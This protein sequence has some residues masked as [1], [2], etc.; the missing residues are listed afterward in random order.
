MNLPNDPVAQLINSPQSSAFPLRRW[1]LPLSAKS[2][3]LRDQELDLVREIVLASCILVI[4]DNDVNIKLVTQILNSA[5]FKNVHSVIRASLALARIQDLKPDLIVLDLRMPFV[6][7][8]EIMEMM[9]A[10]ENYLNFGP[11]LVLTAD[12][13]VETKRKALDAGADDFLCYPIDAR[14]L[15]L[16]VS[17]LL[18]GHVLRRKLE[19][20]N[21]DL[22]NMIEAR[23]RALEDTAVRFR[24]LFET[25][26][27]GI[28]LVD[29]LTG[30]IVEANPFM[31]E[32]LGYC[33]AEFVGKQLYEIGMYEDE[34]ANRAAFAELLG[35][36]YTRHEDRPLR[37]K[38]GGTISVDLVSNVYEEEDRQII[39]YNI[40][41]VSGRRRAQTLKKAQAAE[42]ESKAREHSLRLGP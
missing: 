42:L 3:W 7:G 34:A 11:V 41:D 1:S 39:Q 33:R 29:P 12:I 15:C 13:S 37:T 36:H 32:L 5:G 10:E 27:D 26:R 40:R 28:L 35:K 14:E 20:R 31:E 16:R 4:D 17:N 2:G 38:N 8:V 19:S 23:T 30:Q 22:Q 9:A 25:A 18:I 24:R 6:S 21:D